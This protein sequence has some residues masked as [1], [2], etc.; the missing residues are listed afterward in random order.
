M[1]AGRHRRCANPAFANGPVQG[2][3][4]DAQEPSR[5]TRADKAHAGRTG[6]GPAGEVLDVVD[7]EPA[8]PTGSDDRRLEQTPCDGAQNCRAADAEASC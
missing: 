3:L 1:A 8:V 7:Q 5:L 2:R 4:A 6:S